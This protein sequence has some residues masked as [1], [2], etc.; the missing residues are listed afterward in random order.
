[1]KTLLIFLALLGSAVPT[2]AQAAPVTATYKVGDAA[3][4][5]FVSADG[6]TPFTFQW[7]KNG[8]PITGATNPAFNFAA[9]T[10]ADAGVYTLTVRNSSGQATSSTASISVNVPAGNVLIRFEP[11]PPATTVAP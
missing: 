7:N 5:A 6:T 10:V 3:R 1:M 4:L 11:V 9:I 2:F 8:V